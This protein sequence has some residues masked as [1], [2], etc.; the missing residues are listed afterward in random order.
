MISLRFAFLLKLS[1]ILF[2]I[3]GF[4]HFYLFVCGGAAR[5][6]S[7]VVASGGFSL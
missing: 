4:Q 1:F 2:Y 6:F 7:L 5:R 3:S